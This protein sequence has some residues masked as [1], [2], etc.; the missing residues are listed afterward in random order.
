[1]SNP[2]TGAWAALDPTTGLFT[3]GGVGSYDGSVTIDQAATVQLLAMRA[4]T[5]GAELPSR[6]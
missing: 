4:I 6:R 5:T 3:A 1:M 2:L